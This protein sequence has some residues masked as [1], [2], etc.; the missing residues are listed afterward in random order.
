MQLA[1]SIMRRVLFFTLAPSALLADPVLT[2]QPSQ[3]TLNS[4]VSVSLN[5]NIQGATDVFAFQFDLSLSS[6]RPILLDSVTEG[7]FLSSGRS[8][9]FVPGTIRSGGITGVADTLLGPVPGV[10]GD[11]SLATLDF[12]TFSPSP[13]FDFSGTTTISLSN[14]ILLNSHLA[15]IPATT[16]PAV[17]NVIPEPATWSFVGLA[18]IGLAWACGRRARVSKI[19]ALALLLLVGSAKAAGPGYTFTI[20]AQTGNTIA[21]K[22]LTSVGPPAINNAGT[23]VF[24]GGFSGGA[25]IF[26]PSDLLVQTG[27]TISGK[28][29][30]D[31]GAI[32]NSGAG[33]QWDLA[34][35]DAGTVFF[36]G[37]FS[38]GLGIFTPSQLLVQPGDTVAGETMVDFY[39][40]SSAAPGSLFSINRN[41]DLVFAATFRS[42][43]PNVPSYGIFTLSDL[44]DQASGF[45]G[46]TYYSPVINDAGMVAFGCNLAGE[47]GICLPPGQTPTQILACSDESAFPAINDAGSIVSDFDTEDGNFSGICPLI[48]AS[49][50]TGP[51]GDSIGG[52]KLVLVRYGA[53][54]IDNPGTVLFDATF[55]PS[56]GYPLPGTPG[57]FTSTE[58]LVTGGDTIGGKTVVNNPF[59]YFPA[60]FGHY[61]IN[62][63]GAIVFGTTFTDGSSGIVLATPISSGVAGDINGDGAV[64]CTDMALIKTLFGRTYG[65]PGFDPRADM[66]G[67]GVIDIRD[68]A[69]VAQHLLAGASCP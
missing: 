9:F 19:A 30:T 1:K 45:F 38:G 34:I 23:V 41:G 4:G 2:I 69:F 49:Y 44:V 54:A 26:T 37:S 57:L 20:L 51:N 66:N 33:Y 67:D 31:F 63:A 10:S 64:D 5:V 14:I 27:D 28:T 59:P 42:P 40:Q 12:H 22:T 48:I 3:L 36:L 43:Y 50:G 68:L 58:L 21:G 52:K 16:V 7:S 15:E 53:P 13:G 65:Q 18:L 8:T 62:D 46:R 17:V 6:N 29:L 25:G 35:S 60:Y 32:S 47:Y 61:A 24:L 39:S 56:T 55:A 11:G